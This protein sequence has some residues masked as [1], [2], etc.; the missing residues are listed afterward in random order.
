MFK[1]VTFAIQIFKNV[2]K[3]SL[4]VGYAAISN[5]PSLKNLHQNALHS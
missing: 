1:I 4:F 3:E 2:I 5:R